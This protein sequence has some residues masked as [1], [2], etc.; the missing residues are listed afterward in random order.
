MGF[1]CKMMTSPDAKFC[2]IFG[3]PDGGG[4]GGGGDDKKFCQ[5]HSISQEPCLI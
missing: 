5:S 2:Q 1:M 3:F 4:G